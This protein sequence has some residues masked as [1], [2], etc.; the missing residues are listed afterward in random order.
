MIEE[1]ER[2]TRD[3]GVRRR[4]PGYS[5]WR[6]TSESTGMTPDHHPII[7]WW[8]EFKVRK[9]PYSKPNGGI[10][11]H[12]WKFRSY[13]SHPRHKRTILAMN[14]TIRYL[15]ELYNPTILFGNGRTLQRKHWNS[16]SSPLFCCL[17]LLYH[18]IFPVQRSQ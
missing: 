12:D 14:T 6:R 2:I 18:G 15:D 13:F 16:Y 4:N 1:W 8:H 10:W 7:I 5:V 3:D 9:G 11:K 17:L